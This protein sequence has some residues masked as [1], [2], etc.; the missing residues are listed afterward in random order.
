MKT[1]QA[2]I[3]TN[4]E[5]CQYYKTSM[6]FRA[7][8]EK[9]KIATILLLQSGK[10]STVLRFHWINTISQLPLTE[11]TTEEYLLRMQVFNMVITGEKRRFK[12]MAAKEI[13]QSEEKI[14]NKKKRDAKASFIFFQIVASD[15]PML[16][17]Q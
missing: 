1:V 13:F 11:K 8:T 16:S 10:I 6:S 4:E 5:E 12:N 3:K 7:A 15:W 14:E 17:N 2:I 9:Y